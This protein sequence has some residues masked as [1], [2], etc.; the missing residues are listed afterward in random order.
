MV[1]Q[2]GIARRS[3]LIVIIVIIVNITSI[4]IIDTIIITIVLSLPWF[5]HVVDR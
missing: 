5:V 3:Y 4:I 1:E 2:I